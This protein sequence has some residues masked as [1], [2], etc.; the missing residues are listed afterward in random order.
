M[1][2]IYQKINF[3]NSIKKLN[4]SLS[5][6]FLIFFLTSLFFLNIPNCV[7]GFSEINQDTEI[8]WS[9]GTPLPL[10][11]RELAVALHN[12]LIYVIGGAFDDQTILSDVW[13]T[14]INDDGTINN[15]V[16]TTPLPE[17]RF[18]AE[19]IICTIGSNDFLYV[20]AGGYIHESNSVFYAIINSDGQIGEWK[21]T[22]ALLPNTLVQHRCV[23]YNNWIY[24]VGGLTSFYPSNVYRGKIEATGDI[25]KWEPME[26]LPKI[27]RYSSVSL[28]DNHIFVLGGHQNGEV[29]DEI[30]FSTI[31][32]DGSLNSWKS[33]QTLPNPS[34]YHTSLVINQEIFI[35]GGSTN[36]QGS[37]ELTNKIYMAEIKTDASLSTFTTISS[38]PEAR[39]LHGSIVN[40]GRFYVIGGWNKEKT[41]T[42]S[43]FIGSF[44]SVTP[45]PLT[46][47]DYD[48][49]ASPES[50]S[51][52]AGGSSVSYTVNAALV[53]GS[54]SGVSLS[55]REPPEWLTWGFSL[56]SGNPTFSSVLTVSASGAAP[57]G[58]YTLYVE[59]SGGGMPDHLSD[60][61]LTVFAP[62]ITPT[63]VSSQTLIDFNQI[64]LLA[65]ITITMIAI[66][67][68]LFVLNRKRTSAKPKLSVADLSQT[69]PR[70][71]KHVCP[72]CGGDLPG[73]AKYCGICGK[74]TNNQQTSAADLSQAESSEQGLVCPD[75]GVYLPRDAKYCGIC[76]KELS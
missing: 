46:P 2:T 26:P 63:P 68:A 9:E 66:V 62:T 69:K 35:I 47:D 50:R 32:S 38:L 49:S 40:N 44:S 45:T 3:T 29:Y 16:N 64:L 5:V 11:R 36:S 43:V 7:T 73:D 20:I 51:V 19:A 10:A 57:A 75:C 71:Q 28:K 22:N 55:L 23:V 15:W 76:G 12:N 27:L 52:T 53:S 37:L 58:T 60:V 18:A 54:P 41:S 67:V 42:D 25:L 4:I 74:M 70:E 6:L 13:F 34:T 31:N 14:K 65:I 56:G 24:I 33:M 30:Y 59:G 21:L 48:L 8:I 17:G 61:T 39:G 1:S 72:N